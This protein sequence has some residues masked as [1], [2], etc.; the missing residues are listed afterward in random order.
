MS[1]YKLLIQSAKQVVVVR[2]NGEKVVQGKDMQKLDILESK[3]D[4]GIN[5]LINR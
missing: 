5:I 3:E 2:S 4:D 1:Q